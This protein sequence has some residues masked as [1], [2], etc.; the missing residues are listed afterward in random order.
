MH[1]KK[2]IHCTVLLALT[3]GSILPATGQESE[4]RIPLPY[5]YT[6]TRTATGDYYVITGEELKKYPSID[7]RNAFAGIVPGLIITERDGSTGIAAEETLG[8]NGITPKITETIRSVSPIYV[9]D[10]IPLDITEMPLDPEEIETVTFVK[11]IVGKTMF[12]PRAAD[13]I[14]F[15]KT[16]RGTNKDRVLNINAEAGISVVDRFPD[17]VSGADY[18]QL[19]NQ[20]RTNDGM[21]P[22]YDNHAITQYGKN[23]PY[24]LYFPSTNYKDL[25][26]NKEKSYRKVNVSSYGGNN[27][28]KY[29][30]Y[31]GY[32]GEGDIFKMNKG[33]YNRIN[34]R[35]NL[36]LKINDLLS[37]DVG[38]FGGLSLR[39]SPNYEY[40]TEDLL[41]FNNAIDDITRISPIA[42][43]IY[44]KEPSSNGIPAYGLSN[45]FKYN[46]I[47][48]LNSCGYY[49]ENG[50]SGRVNIALNLDFSQWVK[51]LTARTY[52]DFSAYNLTRIGKNEQF[53]GYTVTPNADYTDVN[54]VEIQKLITASAESKL[55]DYYY[56]KFSGYQNVSYA[57][58]F[59]DDYQVQ[60]SLT[61]ALSKFTRDGVENPLC[62]QNLNLAASFIYKN[63]YA[64]DAAMSY[65]G[66]QAL[67]GKNQY[68]PFPSAG[69]SWIISQE[70]FMQDVSFI[71]NLKLRIQGGMLGV[72]TSSPMLFHY[73]NKWQASSGDKFGPNSSGQW[74]GNQGQ[75]APS[76]TFYNKWKNP[77]LNWE[78]RKEVSVGINT[79]MLQNRLSLVYNYYNSLQDNQWV[80]PYNQYPLAAGFLEVPYV[81]Y[82]Q[83]R[84]YGSE[85]AARYTDKINKFSYSIGANAAL[86]RSKYERIDEPKYKNDYQ[87]R[88]GKPVD[89]YFGLITAGKYATD[90]EA[91][92]VNQLFD[93]TLHA[94]DLKYVDLNNDGAIDNNDMAPIGNTSP[95]F[96]YAINIDLAYRN[97]ELHIVGDG[98]TGFDIPMTNRYFMNG[99]GDNTYSQFVAE[100]IDSRYPRLTYNKVNNNFQA[101]D[102]WLMKGNYFKIQNIELAY[103][104]HVDGMKKVGLNKVR[105][106][107]RGANLLTISKVKDV[108]PESVNSGVSVY[109][110][111]RTFTAGFNLTF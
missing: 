14:I 108:D 20:A 7:L 110:L 91:Q 93:A 8:R 22:L 60:A 27:F 76:A 47:G 5:G 103:N 19:N 40:N 72:L 23:N 94:G 67:I 85:I 102:F 98:K 57:A 104:L 42:F 109:P 80:R 2:Y 101:S 68:R 25:M 95:R 29:Y 90:E 54:V 56:Q 46:P 59:A 45:N 55:H 33:D 86:P 53:A 106:F 18:A 82:N 65:A 44:A 41:D 9:V 71:N 4:K 15:I 17:W 38:I 51:G 48:A 43:P 66:T 35:A 96:Y 31:L 75:W 13:G 111:N 1:S 84:Y 99:W 12:G 89:T 30:A 10:D 62:E 70:D 87:Y 32:A 88:T 100:N 11:D 83:T 34:A 79:T 37:V 92:K 24:D 6:H 21:Q 78:E 74:M 49:N 107:V 97:F 28:V 61:Y 58:T 39:K 26:F 73:E 52:F 50:R 63:K 36:D 81:N 64:V 16:K 105:F 3:V 77:H 69:A